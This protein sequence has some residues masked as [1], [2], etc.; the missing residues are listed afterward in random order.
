ME[1][2]ITW[3]KSARRDNVLPSFNKFK[4]MYSPFF[5]SVSLLGYFIHFFFR[6]FCFFFCFGGGG[7]GEGG[8]EVFE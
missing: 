2:K 7:G 4:K 5:V 8:V 1:F 6:F 3:N